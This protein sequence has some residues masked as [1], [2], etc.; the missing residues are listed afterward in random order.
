MAVRD[1]LTVRLPPLKL[2]MASMLA[3]R[4][5]LMIALLVALIAGCNVRQSVRCSFTNIGK[6]LQS[7]NTQVLGDALECAMNRTP[8]ELSQHVP[9]LLTHVRDTSVYKTIQ[10]GGGL[11]GFGEAGP[12]NILIAQMATRVFRKAAPLESNVEPIVSTLVS[13]LNSATTASFSGEYGDPS[14]IAGEMKETL[15]AYRAAGL[16]TVIARVLKQ[17]LRKVTNPVLGPDSL[18]LPELRALSEGLLPVPYAPRQDGAAITFRPQQPGRHGLTW[19]QVRVAAAQMS[20]RCEGEPKESMDHPIG[21]RCDPYNGDTACTVTLPVLCLEPASRILA[22]SAP[23]TGKRL[24]SRL[25]ADQLCAT[26]FGRGWR[27]AE[28]HDGDWGITASGS[29]PAAPTRAWV[30]IFDQRANCWDSNE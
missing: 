17:Q 11:I 20:A 12:R 13:G 29:P 28:H 27:M 7:N 23:T 16:G 14:T 1:G 8:Q 2:R 5:G 10:Y 25:E 3:I 22:L 15:D 9:L 24:T 6:D 30:A 21:G 18:V 19:G 26:E 4:R